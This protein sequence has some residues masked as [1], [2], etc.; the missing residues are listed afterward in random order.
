MEAAST[1]E[2]LVHFYKTTQRNNPAEPSL[3]LHYKHVALVT[4]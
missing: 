2:A 1:S 4:H 3:F